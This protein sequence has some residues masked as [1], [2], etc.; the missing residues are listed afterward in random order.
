MP[1]RDAS[2]S[3]CSGPPSRDRCATASPTLSSVGS[4]CSFTYRR[5]QRPA[6]RRNLRWSLIANRAV[7]S[8]ASA[9]VSHPSSRAVASARATL[10]LS[11]ARR[12]TAPGWPWDVSFGS[13]S[14]GRTV[15]RPYRWDAV[16]CAGHP[17]TGIAW[18]AGSA[19]AVAALNAIREE[20]AATV[21]ASS[22]CLVRP[23]SDSFGRP[24]VTSSGIPG[25]QVR[26]R[27]SPRR[28]GRPPR[29]AS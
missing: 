27:R 28:R 23:L 7:S 19:R 17:W 8:S 15:A 22:A 4:G 6:A 24:W 25:L 21:S 26:A 20:L 16:I 5:S 13:Q 29:C 14:W 3:A 10:P 9:R 11:I 1:A 12:K 2:A 18:S